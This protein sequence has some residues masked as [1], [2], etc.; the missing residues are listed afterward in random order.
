M[1][2]ETKYTIL[3]S[4][5]EQINHT[6]KELLYIIANNSKIT[7]ENT[8]VMKNIIIFYFVLTL[9]SLLLYLFIILVK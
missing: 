7:R 2:N 3:N 9:F 4:Y 6:D 1:D 8:K 5:N